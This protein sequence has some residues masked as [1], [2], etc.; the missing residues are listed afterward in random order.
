V[1]KAP[2]TNGFRD[3]S[4]QG[5]KESGGH[6]EAL[7]PEHRRS[8]GMDQPDLLLIVVVAH[9][10]NARIRSKHPFDFGVKRV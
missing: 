7:A 3:R 8:E 1:P 4:V 2:A 5:R 6:A 9:F 10:Q